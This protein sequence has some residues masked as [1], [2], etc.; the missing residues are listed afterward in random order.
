MATGASGR[1]IVA[2]HTGRSG[3]VEETVAAGAGA[4]AGADEPKADV[5]EPNAEAVEPLT[6]PALDARIAGGTT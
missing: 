5:D 6:V 3:S 4:G 2:C 1:T